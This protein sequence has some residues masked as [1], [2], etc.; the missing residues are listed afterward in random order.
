MPKVI[1]KYLTLTNF[2]SFIKDFIINYESHP[3]YPSLYA[4]TDSLSL[5]GIENLAAKVSKEQFFEIPITFLSY[6]DDELILVERKENEV[7]VS[8][9]DN[10]QVSFTFIDFFE[11]WNG[12]ILV[13]EENNTQKV[14]Q[15]NTIRV[16]TKYSLL[17][18]CLLVVYFLKNQESFQIFT[19]LGF[20]LSFI[21]FVIALFIIDEKYRT[22]ENQLTSKICSFSESTSCSKVIK[23]SSP[24]I[25]RWVEFSDLPILFFAS[26]LISQLLNGESIFIISLLSILSLP[27]VAYS[28]WLQKVKIKK[29]CILCITVSSILLFLSI[30][31][32]FNQKDLSF[33]VTTDFFIIGIIVSVVWFIIKLNISNN[34]NLTKENL[35]LM[36]F[37]RNPFIF[38]SLLKKVSSYDSINS[39]NRILIGKKD[40]PINLTLILSPSCSHCHIA[41]EESLEIYKQFEDKINISI[42]FNV[43]PNNKLNNYLNVVFMILMI[44]KKDSNKILEAIRDLHIEKLSLE[45]WFV[46]WGN[47]ATNNDFENEKLD[48]EQQYNWCQKNNFNF[49]PV[50]L[51][52][53]T[54]YPTEYSVS[55]IKYFISELEEITELV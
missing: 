44:N 7:L 5:I 38:K 27:L 35:D 6:L 31:G 34:A 37:K 1:L 4:I 39:F 12:I 2:S 40:V 22:N 21:G 19:F 24:L 50:R 28:I 20:I 43:N 42:L 54:I 8:S 52:N 3:D 29:W 11:V 49:T 53:D 13:V 41:F 16:F 33:K 14:F 9:E 18:G 36:K 47:N 51:V 30:L 46:K 23:S 10:K 32:W 25:S 45:E 17:L 26:A 48:L 55:D 15:N